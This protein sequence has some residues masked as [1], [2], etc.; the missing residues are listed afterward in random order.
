M[1]HV[2]S[3]KEKKIKR[4]TPSHFNTNYRREMKLI[5]INK[6]Y[7]LLQFVALNVFLWIR[8]HGGSLPNFKFFDINP[9]IK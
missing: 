6:D 2:Q 5:T 9:Q 8:L 1:R 7:C 3:V 4:N